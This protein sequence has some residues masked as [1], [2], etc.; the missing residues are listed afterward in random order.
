MTIFMP[1]DR[2]KLREDWS[3]RGVVVSSTG[4]YSIVRWDG[5]TSEE[6]FRTRELQP[7]A[8]QNPE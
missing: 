6:C 7:L 5:S 8:E 1:G 4:H 2:V 3:K